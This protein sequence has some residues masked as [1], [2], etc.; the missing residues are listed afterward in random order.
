MANDSENVLQT[1]RHSGPM[2]V[3][4]LVI[5]AAVGA[6]IGAKAGGLL[7]HGMGALTGGC[8]GAVLGGFAG[9]GAGHAAAHGAEHRYA[10]DPRDLIGHLVLDRAGHRLGK[11][12]SVY[13]AADG[14]PWYIGVATTWIPAGSVHLMPTAGVRFSDSGRRLYMPLDG[15]ALR[16]SPSL[17]LDGAIDHTI[18]DALWRHYEPLGLRPEPLVE[19]PLS[20]GESGQRQEDRWDLEPLELAHHDLA[21]DGDPPYRVALEQPLQPLIGSGTPWTDQG[22]RLDQPSDLAPA[23][24]GRSSTTVRSD[25]RRWS[26]GSWSCWTAQGWAARLSAAS[27]PAPGRRPQGTAPR[28]GG[29]SR[30]P[31]RRRSRPG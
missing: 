14:H 15:E 12:A 17:K 11:V 18:E 28:P 5:G 3:I 6:T 21:L 1:I 16:T 4:G 13:L 27:A 10:G 30:R 26:L 24:Q 8:I 9:A 7:G 19:V 2:T 22:P 20:A 23:H 31:Q 25:G 29:T